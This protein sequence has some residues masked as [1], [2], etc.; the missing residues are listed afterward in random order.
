M[1][2]NDFW[3]NTNTLIKQQNTT[4]RALALRC[5]FTE[6]RIESLSSSA[7]LPDAV[8]AVKIAQALGTTVE[9]LVTGEETNKAQQEL[10]KLK[11]ILRELSQ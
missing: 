9:Y 3:L 7:R 5:G 1:I 10:D 11:Q 2:Y 8:E 6:R 4:Q